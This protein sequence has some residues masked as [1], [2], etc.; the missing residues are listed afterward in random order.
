MHYFKPKHKLSVRK[1]IHNIITKGLNNTLHYENI[2][3]KTLQ[4]MIVILVNKSF[5]IQYIHVYIFKLL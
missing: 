5:Y 4:K 3:K 2:K 1:Y